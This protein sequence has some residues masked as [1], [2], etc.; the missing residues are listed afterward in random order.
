ME[1]S[2]SGSSTP[3]DIEKGESQIQKQLTLTFRNLNVRVTA[4][5]AALGSTLWSEVDPRQLGKLFKRRSSPQRTIFKDISGQVKPGEMLLI[6]G[7]PGSGCTSLLNVLSNNRDTFNEVTGETRYGSMDH[8]AARQFRQQIM[9]NNEDD[10]HFPTLTVNRTM[11]FALRNK[12]PDERPQQLR[13]RK[14]FVQEKRDDILDSLGINHTKKTLVG[15]EFIRGVSGGERKRVSLAEVM[16]GQSPVQMWD[17]PIRGLD[18]KAAVEFARMLRRE[19]DDNRKTILATM[20]QAG[21]GIYDEFDKIL[22]L[23]EGRVTY[24]GPRSLAR[25]YFEDLG[26]DCPRG[27]NIA[28][29]LT[30]VT[31]ITERLV[32]PGW[33][34][35][36]PNT[37]EEFEAVYH[38]V[39]CIKLRWMQL[40]QLSI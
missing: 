18:S 14:D 25:K 35:K 7:R 8:V 24:Y 36:V 11:K 21:N 15:N 40:C 32:R 3:P 34:E 27:A 28:D 5:D 6:L 39:S 31:V 12:V 10:L 17:N 29:F 9:F 20:Y 22:V 30:S 33:E 26:F 16:A 1:T 2:S 23:A 13:K 37:P 4:P 19:A 38:A